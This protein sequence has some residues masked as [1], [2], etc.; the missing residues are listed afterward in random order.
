[1]HGA[2]MYLCRQ[3]D[4]DGVSRQPAGAGAGVQLARTTSAT[5]EMIHSA[6]TNSTPI[7]QPQCWET[8]KASELF[9][10]C[11]AMHG[12]SD[13]VRSRSR[14]SAKPKKA[15]GSRNAASADP[16]WIAAEDQAGDDRRRPQAVPVAQR[17]EEEAAEEELLG[18]RRHDGDQQ[19]HR[20]QR[21]GAVLD[22][23]LLGSFESSGL[24]A[25]DRHPPSVNA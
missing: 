7:S 24:D 11:S 9:T 25:Q 8:P 15:S 22:A 21:D 5:S 2:E 1:M 23:E 19:G 10:Q 3:S 4:R 17:A 16:T 13:P 12:Y 20:E 18:H 6:D 14:H